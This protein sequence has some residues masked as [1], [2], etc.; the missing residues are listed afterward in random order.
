M[1]QPTTEETQR[2]PGQDKKKGGAYWDRE[3]GG[4]QE[5]AGKEKE[6]SHGKG[7]CK[8]FR[9]GRGN[10]VWKRAGGSHGNRDKSTQEPGAGEPSTNGCKEQG[11]GKPRAGGHTTTDS[12]GM[13]ALRRCAYRPARTDGA[14]AARQAGRGGG[15]PPPAR[16]HTRSRTPITPRATTYALATIA[17]VVIGC[18]WRLGG[19]RGW[20]GPAGFAP[21]ARWVLWRTS[22]TWCLTAQSMPACV[23]ITVSPFLGS[24]R[25]RLAVR[26]RGGEPWHSSLRRIRWRWLALCTTATVY[27]WLET[28]PAAASLSPSPSARRPRLEWANVAVLAAPASPCPACVGFFLAFSDSFTVFPCSAS[29]SS[30]FACMLACHPVCLLHLASSPR[31]DGGARARALTPVRCWPDEFPV[32]RACPFLSAASGC[33]R[34]GPVCV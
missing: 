23:P 13:Y 20:T 29:L 12:K 7:R 14:G 24:V 26:W 32:L 16:C 9:K 6:G 18:G 31:R 21:T 2:Q 22:I 34:D 5:G 17:G 19:V 15:G 33:N 30:C 1:E 11:R 8:P 3:K 25:V 4:V 10:R 27:R 28:T